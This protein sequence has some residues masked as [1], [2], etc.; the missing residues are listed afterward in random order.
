MGKRF[1]SNLNYRLMNPT[2]FG[3]V[4]LGHH[5]HLFDLAIAQMS[6]SARLAPEGCSIAL[7]GGST[8]KAFYQWA[9]RHGSL[10]D[11]VATT[12]HWTTSDE[13]C[14]PVESEESNFGTADREFLV[15]A[16]IPAEKKHPWP[17]EVEPMQ[18]AEVYRRRWEE[19]FSGRSV[20]DLC[21][22][23]MGDDCHTASL[24]PGSELIDDDGGAPFAA[25]EVPGKGHR[26]TITPS[27]LGGCAMIVVMVAG[28]GKAKAIREV[29]TTSPDPARRPIQLLANFSDRVLWLL[30]EA[31]G[32]ML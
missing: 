29:F 21:F 26:L 20:Y 14:V 3:N 22:L 18:A 27:G 13:R 7:T 28:E 19:A 17:T 6:E 4:V 11:E 16:G 12:A 10:P 5:N 24:F 25:V 8:P 30:D 9:I 15:P 2:P 23:G 1:F 32:S 31:A